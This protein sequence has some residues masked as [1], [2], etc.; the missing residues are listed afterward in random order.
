MTL[1]MGVDSSTQ[2]C[3]VVITDAA[4]GAIVRDGRA[5]H[6]NGTEVDPAAWWTALQAAIDAA[7]GL[8]DVKSWAIGGQMSTPR[9]CSASADGSCKTP[10]SGLAESPNRNGVIRAAPR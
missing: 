10:N 8:G 3:K 9:P 7:G 1:V 6:P 5:I 2:S 4:T